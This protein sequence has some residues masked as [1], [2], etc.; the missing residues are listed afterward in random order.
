MANTL[1]KYGFVF[2]RN[3]SDEGTPM[4]T[5]YTTS[6]LT[7]K[8][9]DPVHLSTTGLAVKATAVSTKA[10]YIYGF[11]AEPITA[12]VGTSYAM[13]IVPARHDIVF[14]ACSCSTLNV[15]KGYIGR[16]AGIWASGLVAYGGNPGAP[17]LSQLQIVGILNGNAA[18][19]FGTY[20]ELLY[21]VHH[22]Q[23]TGQV[24]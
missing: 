14:R 1:S 12:K 23:F 10:G 13:R 9:G 4:E 24:T 5:V 18:G 15:T 3:L 6:N 21:I 8:V 2:H 19:T 17:T 7:F 16:G 22:S 20:A 11:A